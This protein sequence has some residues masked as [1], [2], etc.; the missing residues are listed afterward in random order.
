MSHDPSRPPAGA[1]AA[2]PT[3]SAPGGPEWA[4]LIER[5]ARNL[6]R[7]SREWTAAR[8]KTSL[9]RVLTGSRQDAGRL[10]QRLQGLMTAWEQD[11]PDGSVEAAAEMAEPAATAG[12]AGAE[13]P[14]VAAPPVSTP[15]SSVLPAA[16]PHGPA[17]SVA[18]G[19]PGAPNTPDAQPLAAPEV[20]PSWP[21]IVHSLQATVA[22]ALPPAETAAA[23]LA[24]ELADL[25][26]RIAAQGATPPL[27]QSV[28]DCCERARVLLRHRHHLVDELAVLSRQMAGSL[29]E[30]S[31][32][33]VW[34][35]AQ[36]QTLQERLA[37]PPTTRTVRAAAA[38]LA[39]TRRQQ[40]GLLQDRVAARDALKALIGQMV[41][42][43][44]S[45]DDHTGLFQHAVDRHAQAIAG[46]DSVQG[47]AGVV[48]AL[49]QDS[50]AVRDAVQGSR[51]RLEQ[52]R[53]QADALAAR[54][55]EL[56]SELRRL[57]DEVATDALTQVA[58]RRGL[59]QA[60][61]VVS[62]GAQRDGA[63][64]PGAT[65]PP[66]A[67]A[68]LDIDHFKRLNDALGHAAG[69]T[70]LKALAAAVRERL[71]PADHVARL[72]GEEFVLLLPHTPL[73]EAQQ[74]LARLQRKLTTA[75]FM[76]EGKEVFVTFSAG[77]TLWRP[78]EP[79][80]ATLDRADQALYE[81][82]RTGRNRCC[83]S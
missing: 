20:P 16:A 53:V 50:Q 83:T 47:L 64:P 7:G 72:G 48:R 23:A 66:L 81:A 35:A 56:E 80:D 2:S 74:V 30:L 25:A 37:S 10:L 42:E 32:D 21:R 63:Q 43:L 82:K 14:A 27:A 5:L 65:L 28:A 1:P 68:L 41:G 52:G 29:A 62:A 57:S 18:P 36:C 3:A 61:A 26:D 34:V 8:R 19:P 70:A 39:D 22:A 11:R 76:H 13:A 71:R 38:L 59:A 40:Q 55:R 67:V 4:L 58:N 6:E 15:A 73:D 9:Q 77:V 69:D 46:A 44:A 31:E 45:L 12:T 78:G 75:L 33:S 49:L 79:L 17:V 24:D 54:V 60:F 51:S